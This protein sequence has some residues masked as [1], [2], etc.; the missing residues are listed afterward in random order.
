MSTKILMYR[1]VIAAVL[2][3]STI[4]ILSCTDEDNGLAPYTGSPLMSGITVEQGTFQPKVTW[5]G[6]YVSVFGVNKGRKARLDSTLVMLATSNG[7]DIMYPVTFGEIPDNA[8]NSISQFGGNPIDNL[9][10]D[11]IYTYWVMKNDLWNQVSN[12]SDK[13]F[14]ATEELNAGTYQVVGDTLLQASAYSFVTAESQLDVYVNVADVVTFGKLGIISVSQPVDELGPEITWT[15][16]QDG[17]TDTR[18]SAMG[19][20]EG[21]G[22]NE[23]YQIWDL[24][25]WETIDGSNVYGK[26]NVISQPI[27]FGDEQPETRNFIEYPSEGLERD[28]VYY[29]WIANDLWDGVSRIRVTNYYAYCTFRTW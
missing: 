16:T 3:I 18:I 7:D 29:I 9:L 5:I 6:G 15:I 20:V 8:Q 23:I 19:L 13:F 28:K 1:L 25:S 26:K 10:E 14:E 21:Q 17:V 24:W 2:L 22:Y 27:R 12:Q 4:I 11:E